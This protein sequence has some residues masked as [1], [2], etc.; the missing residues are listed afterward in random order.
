L[1][2]S[3]R[4]GDAN[5]DG[6]I[7]LSELVEHVELLVPKLVAESEFGGGA[8]EVKTKSVAERQTARYGSRGE[9]FVLVK[10][11]QSGRP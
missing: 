10:R 8:N 2:D 1:L 4:N 7:S 9:D 11:L 3:L 5:G 6:L